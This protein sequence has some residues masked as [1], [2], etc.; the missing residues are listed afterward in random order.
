[1]LPGVIW[2][3]NGAD[4]ARTPSA[5]EGDVGNVAV[6]RWSSNNEMAG[7]DGADAVPR[8]SASAEGT[9]LDGGGVWLTLGFK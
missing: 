8:R 1:L 6:G 7:E 3:A 9:G 4:G 2:L 5:V